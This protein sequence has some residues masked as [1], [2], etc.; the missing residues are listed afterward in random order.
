MEAE[1]AFIALGGDRFHPH[2]RFCTAGFSEGFVEYPAHTAPSMLG[3]NTDKMHVS[4]ANRMIGD[5]A[6]KKTDHDPL[7]FDHECMF[8]E[9]VEKNRMRESTDGPSPPAIDHLYDV[10]KVCFCQG[11]R[12]HARSFRSNGRDCKAKSGSALDGSGRNSA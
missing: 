6:Q 4:G 11:S 1:R 5:K 7:F 9:L 10:V 3:V 2:T 8:T 12:D